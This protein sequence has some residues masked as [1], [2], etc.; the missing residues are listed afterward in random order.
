[1]SDPYDCT[2]YGEEH[3]G[4]D[5]E[6]GFFF[7]FPDGEIELRQADAYAGPGNCFAAQKVNSSAVFVRHDRGEWHQ[8]EEKSTYAVLRT[9]K[10]CTS[11]LSVMQALGVGSNQA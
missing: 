8:V 3:P 4:T 11:A 5:V 9:I 2:D 6:A 10:P 7:M 1:M